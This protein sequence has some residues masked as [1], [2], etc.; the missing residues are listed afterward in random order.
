[1]PKKNF[2][3][4]LGLI[5]FL[6]LP[7]GHSQAAPIIIDHNTRSISLI[8]EVQINN[9]KSDLHIAYGHTSHGS[10]LIDGM[11]GL[12]TFMNNKGATNNLYAWNN[13]G[14]DGALDLHDGAMAGDVG[15]YPDWVN[16]TRAYLGTPDGATGRGTGLNADVN[17]IIWSWCGQVSSLDES[18]MISN[19]LAP[20]T[21]LE[22]DYP[23]IKF[24]YMTG[25]LDGG[26]LSGNLHLRNEQ[27]RAY[28]RDN[29]KILYDFEDIESYDPDNVYFGDKI[30]TDNCDY[31]SDANGSQDKNWALDWQGTHTLNVDWYDC[32]AAHSQSLNANLK[33]YAAWWLWAR[34]AGWDGQTSSDTAPPNIPNGLF[35]D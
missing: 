33:A 2:Y 16:Y 29:D 24:V 22:E 27:I 23:G 19:Y 32:G 11:N 28:C 5:L 4:S 21:A 31:D 7:L 18:T 3:F 34:L 13:G 1:M 8:P 26:G 20:M 9:A 6:S 35:V 25:H 30:P 14:I 12:V 15:Y 10:Q 17:V